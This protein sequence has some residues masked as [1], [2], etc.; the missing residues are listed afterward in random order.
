MKTAASRREATSPPAPNPSRKREGNFPLF[1]LIAGEASGDLLGGNLMRG[2]KKK[3]DGKV[4][5]AG[6]GGPRMVASTLR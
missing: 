1:F 6:I 3:L 2:L 5:F 4:H